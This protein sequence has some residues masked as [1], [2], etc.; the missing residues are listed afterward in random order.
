VVSPGVCLPFLF[1]SLTT[2]FDFS[3]SLSLLTF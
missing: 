3:F 2:L 1:S